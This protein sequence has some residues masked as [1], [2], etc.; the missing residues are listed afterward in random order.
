MLRSLM[1]LGLPQGLKLL[2]KF[3]GLVFVSV[4]VKLVE[5]FLFPSLVILLFLVPSEDP[6]CLRIHLHC[7]IFLISPTILSELDLLNIIH[8]Y[9]PHLL[10]SELVPQRVAIPDLRRTVLGLLRL[11]EPLLRLDG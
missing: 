6:S 5:D 4:E 2:S 7:L 9:V 3:G 8:A 11:L 1:V 10:H